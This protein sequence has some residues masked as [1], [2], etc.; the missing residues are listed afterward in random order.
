MSA[1]A[2][3]NRTPPN[4]MP[5]CV[6]NVTYANDTTPQWRLSFG[7]RADHA[8]YDTKTSASF[9][10]GVKLKTISFGPLD[11]PFLRVVSALRNASNPRMLNFTYQGK[12]F[13]NESDWMCDDRLCR[14]PLD[15]PAVGT[16]A[17]WVQ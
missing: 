4:F 1:A 9:P 3:A 5:N 7:A 2:T 11:D 6:F 14:A 10:T 15:C 17:K 13:A 16:G 12:T 8:A